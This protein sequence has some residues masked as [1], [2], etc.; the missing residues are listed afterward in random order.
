VATPEMAVLGV[1]THMVHGGQLVAIL[2]PPSIPHA[3]QDWKRGIQEALLP[4]L[5]SFVPSFLR[6]F[7]LISVSA[8]DLRGDTF[9]VS[10][11][12]HFEGHSFDFIVITW[13]YVKGW[14]WSP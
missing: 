2:L 7:I 5:H 3:V 8:F 4:C 12:S 1:A 13:A 10:V 14:L 6:S 11:S 9:L